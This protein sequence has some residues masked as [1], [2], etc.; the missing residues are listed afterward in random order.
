MTRARQNS[1][2]L[3]TSPE[4]GALLGFSDDTVRKLC[5]DGKLDAFRHGP[6]AHWRIS[7]ASVLELVQRRS[8]VAGVKRR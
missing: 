5:E 7:R 3:L 8:A 6:G 4:A 2:E 1:A